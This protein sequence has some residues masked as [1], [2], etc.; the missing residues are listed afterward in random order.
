MSATHL[1]RRHFLRNLAVAGPAG[2]T[3]MMINPAMAQELPRLALDD[4]L[5][6]ALMYVED[7]SQSKAANYQAGQTCKNCLHIQ[8]N[9]GDAWRPCAIIFGKSVAAA[10]WCN[11]WVAKP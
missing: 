4:P 2:G 6:V 3:L 11:V 10:G 9:D 5:A 1:S 8:G 7:A